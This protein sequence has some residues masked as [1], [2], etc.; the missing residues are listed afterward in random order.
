VSHFC[1]EYIR[2]HT[3]RASCL[4]HSR[5]LSCEDLGTLF[6]NVS[7]TISV[8]KSFSVA[9]MNR[10]YTPQELQ[11]DYF[12]NPLATSHY[13]DGVSHFVMSLGTTV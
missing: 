3:E 7:Q 6:K 10:G 1:Y 13:V 2:D 12:H 9:K 5:E 4:N 8:I 11:F